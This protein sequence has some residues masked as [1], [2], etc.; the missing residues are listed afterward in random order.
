MDHLPSGG[1]GPP[2]SKTSAGTPPAGFAASARQTNQ[3]LAAF[4]CGFDC[5]VLD[6]AAVTISHHRLLRV[7]RYE[8]PARV[9]VRPA[10]LDQAHAVLADNPVRNLGTALEP[11][12]FL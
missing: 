11:M 5:A 2:P 10:P 3:L 4:R 9:H 8:Q 7:L 12:H 6:K 1:L